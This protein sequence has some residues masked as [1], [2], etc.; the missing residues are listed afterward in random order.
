MAPDESAAAAA[1]F[2]AVF[3][4][5]A[6]GHVYGLAL[7]AAALGGVV[8]WLGGEAVHGS[9]E[10]P[11]FDSFNPRSREMGGLVRAGTIREALLSFGMLGAALGLALGLAG[12]L[13]RRS[14]SA[15]LGAGGLGLALAAA[16]G[17]SAAA[18]LVPYYL[19]HVNRDADD[20]LLPL[21]T[22]GGIWASIGAA[23]GLA[24]GGGVGGLRAVMV[25]LLGGLLGA[26]IGT[27]VFEVI[28]PFAFP[29][30]KTGEPVSVTWGSRL[31]ARL[32]IALFTAAGAS[33]ATQAVV[34]KPVIDE[35]S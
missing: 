19:N 20:M 14:A 2:G 12:G 30:A 13:A 25:A 3:K 4:R 24:Y 29:L 28:A 21:L 22:H 1:N 5:A 17:A 27:L 8:A 11:L 18:G 32:A 26:L 33:L 35:E 23:A 6:R 34:S 16:A 7:A 31:L 10:A 15:A 9:F